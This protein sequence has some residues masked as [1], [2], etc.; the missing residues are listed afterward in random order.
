[1]RL[2]LRD[3]AYGYPGRTLGER[4]SLTLGSGELLCLLGP[5]GSGKTTLFKTLLGLL[6]PRAGR[7][8]L[9]GADL[10]SLTRA[11][12]ARRIAYVPQSHT[13][14]FP[15]S[16]AEVVLMGR[17]AHLGPFASPGSIDHAV[18]GRAL[19]AMG[20]AH[21]A[22][23]A[24]TQL[25]GG[26]RQLA[27]IARALAQAAPI[28]VMDEPTSSL[29]FGNQVRVLERIRA[30]KR[31][32]QAIILSTHDPAQA[33]ALADRVALLEQGGIMALGPPQEVATAQTLA[34]LYG[35]SVA[36]ERLANADLVA[37]VPRY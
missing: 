37:V 27:L 6:P 3:L 35:V 9:G 23:R 1:M 17:T 7:V 33:H 18:A 21:L 4:V 19:S 2:E 10:S 34:R 5:N 30:L 26:E 8:L 20:I 31:E 32:G 16:V 24:Y 36:V 11:E 25:S 28:L 12:V 13:A 15:Y 22:N 14:Y 29:D